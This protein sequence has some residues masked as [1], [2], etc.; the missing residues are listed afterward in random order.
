M[1]SSK[2]HAVC[3]RVARIYYPNPYTN[4]KRSA[5][6]Q[7]RNPRKGDGSSRAELGELLLDLQSSWVLSQYTGGRPGSLGMQTQV[8]SQP[9]HRVSAQSEPQAHH[10][11]LRTFS[12]ATQ[13]EGRK[14]H[15]FLRA[16][17]Q[18]EGGQEALLSRWFSF[19]PRPASHS[20][21]RSMEGLMNP[22]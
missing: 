2:E 13:D 22:F 21:P 4:P 14:E 15:P 1:G 3:L 5:P 7:T 9:G 11:H 10:S 18:V 19:C 17:P 6:I 16:R 20:H 12:K 8:C